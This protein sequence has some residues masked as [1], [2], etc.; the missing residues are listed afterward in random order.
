MVTGTLNDVSPAGITM[1]GNAVKSVPKVAVPP[2][3]IGTVISDPLGA[4]SESVT[5]TVPDVSSVTVDA[6]AFHETNTSPS[7]STI[8]RV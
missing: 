1:L 6:V 3:V 2:Y 7:S 8:L 5:D 4:D